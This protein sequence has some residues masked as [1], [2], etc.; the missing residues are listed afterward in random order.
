MVT[1]HMRGVTRHL[2]QV[3]LREREN[4]VKKMI[5]AAIGGALLTG[6]LLGAGLANAEMPPLPQ[7]GE[8]STCGE[9]AQDGVFNIPEGD[10]NYWD[11]GDRDGDGI[12]CEKN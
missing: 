7:A 2:G 1:E 6:S 10:E 8:Y 3:A 9:A 12:A 5:I 4:T 11:E